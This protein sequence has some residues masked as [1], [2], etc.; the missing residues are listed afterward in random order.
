M[1]AKRIEV[2]PDSD[3]ARLLRQAREQPVV[4]ESGGELFRLGRESASD[5]TAS[6]PQRVIQGMEEA[7]G[8]ITPEEAEEWIENIYRWRQEGSRPSDEP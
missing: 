6:D 4:I 1:V 7:R 2:E 3:L 8:V 5:G